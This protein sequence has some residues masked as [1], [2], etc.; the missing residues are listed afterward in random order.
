M[1]TSLKG[2]SSLS[3]GDSR[4]SGLVQADVASLVICDLPEK[5]GVSRPPSQFNRL[6]V[7]RGGVNRGLVEGRVDDIG[8]LQLRRAL[9][10]SCERLQHFGVRIGVVRFCAG[11]VVPQA[12]GRDV[13]SPGAGECNFVLKAILLA[14]QRKNVLVKCSAV[15]GKHIGFQTKGN[16]ACK[17]VNLLKVVIR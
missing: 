16:G 1:S 7:L 10:K 2:L 5:A 15:I 17:H 9:D 13:D 11:F 14:Q 3:R 4:W 8:G 6:T 12:D